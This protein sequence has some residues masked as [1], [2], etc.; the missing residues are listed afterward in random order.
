MLR[1]LAIYRLTINFKK[2]LGDAGELLQLA[3]ALPIVYNL[4]DQDHA[5][6]IGF[7]Q[8]HT[9]SLQQIALQIFSLVY[10]HF[11]KTTK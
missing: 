9:G 5:M 3:I 7:I 8:I 4:M 6:R 2:K 1:I 10:L 11:C